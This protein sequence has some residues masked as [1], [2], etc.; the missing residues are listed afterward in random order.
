MKLPASRLLYICSPYTHGDTKANIEHARRMAIEGWNKGWLVICPQLNSAG[1]ENDSTAGYEDY[2]ALYLLMVD[3]LRPTIYLGDGWENSYG[4][5]R[6]LAVARTYK[7][8]IYI[9]GFDEEGLPD[10]KR[11]AGN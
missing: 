10:R 5:K 11:A 3:E 8:Q 7:G 6:E 9:E 4:C 1:F 2:M